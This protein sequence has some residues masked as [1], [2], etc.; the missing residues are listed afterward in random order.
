MR[1][2]EKEFVEKAICQL[3]RDES[4]AVRLAKTKALDQ[5]SSFRGGNEMSRN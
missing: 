4:E 3:E 2:K 5:V 1:L